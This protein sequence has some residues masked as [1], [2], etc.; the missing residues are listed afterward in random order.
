MGAGGTTRRE[1][2][3]LVGAGTAAAI[4]SALLGPRAAQAR[5]ARGMPA[6]MIQLNGNESPY[7]PST[8]ARAAMTRAQDVAARYPGDL[9]EELRVTLASL[10]GVTPEQIA[11]G[12][13]SGEILRMADMAF[14]GL[15]RKVVV[16]EPT[17]EAVLVYAGVTR[18]EAV[19]VPLDA[20]FRHDLARM[21]EAC[22][23]RCGLVYVCNPN[24]PTGTVV[25]TAQLGAF[26]RR[27][28]PAATVLLDEAYLHFVENPA[29]RSGLDLL[30][31]F[32]NL[33]IVRTFSKVYGMAG[34]RLGYAVAARAK[35][36]AMR[37][38]VT[39]NNANAAVLLAALASL[40][41]SEL[42]PQVK[43]RMNDTRRWLC[44]ELAK[45]GRRAI[46]SEANFVMIDVGGDV[47]PLIDGFKQ[48]KI[49]VGRRFPS[50]PTW[51]RV[52]VGTPEEMVAFLAALR[53]LAPAAVA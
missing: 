28:P 52:S 50:M 24:N 29:C 17:F 14:L 15:D 23:G 16:A 1:L 51:L 8:A 9:E 46:P 18:A 37:Q 33:I 30:P 7:G 6:D 25:T 3:A 22:D 47:A 49:L 2:A 38:H 31:E 34:M 41:D 35:I 12:C 32:P 43:R 36:E 4:A 11:L 26:L 10:H 13:G 48:R 53:A 42:V 20:D 27:V 45:D 44:A 39:F 19:K 21:A 5:L 40:A